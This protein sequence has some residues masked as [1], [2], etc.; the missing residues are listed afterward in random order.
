MEGNASPKK[1]DFNDARGWSLEAEGLQ[2][3][4]SRIEP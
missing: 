2:E 1:S 3:L 4:L